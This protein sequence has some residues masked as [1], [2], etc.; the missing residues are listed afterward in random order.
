M[1]LLWE[2]GSELPAGEHWCPLERWFLRRD[3]VPAGW[4]GLPV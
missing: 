4:W 3:C 1:G 2:A